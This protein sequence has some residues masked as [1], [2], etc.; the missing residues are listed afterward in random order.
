M[1]IDKL[2]PPP[3]GRTGWPWTVEAGADLDRGSTGADRAGWPRITIVTPSYNQGAYLEETI[4]SVLLQGYPNLEYMVADGGSSDGSVEIIR[5]YERHLAWWVSEPDRGPGHALNKAFARSSGEV[6]AY[7]NSDDVY[8]PE[9]LREVGRLCA[10]RTPWVVGTV[11][12]VQAGVGSWPVPQLPGRNVVDWFVTCPIS[13][14]GCFWHADLHRQVGPFREDLQFFFD[15]E[16][17]LRLRFGRKIVPMT[18]DRPVALYRLHDRSKT[19]AE[20]AGFAAERRPIRDAY[21]RRL[22]WFQRAQVWSARRHRRARR[23][24][25]QAV[26]LFASRKRLEALRE[27]ASALAAWPMLAVDWQ[28]PYVVRDYLRGDRPAP[29]DP[30]VFAD[31][32]D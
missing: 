29:T 1:T 16:F 32:D 7:L 27:M 30:A 21:A 8:E 28:N 23:R 10:P 24:R 15:Y 3:V 13:Q 18:V 19:V 26:A 22:P 4:R 25:A 20:A 6:H 12:Y 17:W 5:R 9:A 31:A 14:P 11:R 2:P